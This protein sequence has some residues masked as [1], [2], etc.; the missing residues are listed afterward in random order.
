MD[1]IVHGGLK[2]SDTTEQFSLTTGNSLNKRVN[3]HAFLSLLPLFPASQYRAVLSLVAQLCLTLRRLQPTRLLCPW[4]FFRPEYWSGQ[5]FTPLGDLPNPG[6]GPQ[7]PSLQ[8]DSLPP[9]PPGKPNQ[10]NSQTN[11]L[12]V[13]PLGSDILKLNGRMMTLKHFIW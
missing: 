11:V 1:C 6:M 12:F 5:L 9:E 3:V 13:S 7:P 10:Y 8:A 4:G 2:K